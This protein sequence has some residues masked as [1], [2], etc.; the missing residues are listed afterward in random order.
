MMDFIEQLKRVSPLTDS[1]KTEIVIV[2]DDLSF[3]VMLKDYLYSSGEMN[4][5]NFENGDEFLEKYKHDDSRIIILDYEFGN[6]SDGLTVLTKIKKI[7]PRA[8]V[9]MVSSQDDLEKAVETLRKGAI[10]YFLK[11]NKTVFANILCSI[12]KIMDMERSRLN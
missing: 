12:L 2:D 6:K 4:A 1:T 3:S 5:E 8:M 9:I 11:T 7:N 10:D